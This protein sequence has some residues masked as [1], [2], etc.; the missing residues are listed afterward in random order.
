[1]FSKVKTYVLER[2]HRIAYTALIFAL[3]VGLGLLALNRSTPP[4][5]TSDVLGATE[6]PPKQTVKREIIP[7]T[8]ENPETNQVSTSPLAGQQKTSTDN[9]SLVGDGCSLNGVNISCT[10]Q[11]NSSGD[12]LLLKQCSD[13][14]TELCNFYTYSLGKETDQGVYLFQS[15]NEDGSDLTDVLLYSLSSSTVELVD[16][17][18][19]E[20]LARY[21]DCEDQTLCQNLKTF[22]VDP[23][24][25]ENQV[26]QNNTEFLEIINQYR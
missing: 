13:D 5:P 25:L 16:T 15:Y 18:L 11:N 17:V 1:M 23:G 21:S 26:E 10:I 22:D 12:S 20:D 2:P 9:Y 8:P 19:Y 6:Q 24:S 7:L 3:L 4:S 14:F